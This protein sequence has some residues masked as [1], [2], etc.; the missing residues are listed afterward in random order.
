[1][2]PIGG[3]MSQVVQLPTH[4]GEP[5]FPIFSSMLGDVN[6]V[7]NPYSN[8][9]N[10]EPNALNGAGGAL[11]P[12]L[13]R[14]RAI[15]E[16]L[17]RYSSCVF[18]ERQFIWA[19]AEELGDEALDLNTVPRC[20]PAELAHPR[21]PL[22][23]PNKRAPIRWVR[24]V[25]LLDARPV[26]IPG[27]MAYLKLAMLS[28]GERF[29]LPISTGCA[30]HVT[31]EQALLAGVGEV[32]ER[33]SI[34]LVWLQQLEL[35][36]IELDEVPPSLGG[37]LERNARSANGVETLFFDATTE[38]G[39][40]TVYSL[41]VSPQNETLAA[42]VMCSTELDAATA[43]AKIIREAASSRIAMLQPRPVPESWDDFT[44]VM[45]GAA[46]MGR[47]AQ[48]PAFDFL[49]HSTGRRRLSDMP[50][51]A[52][53]DARRD[54]AGLLRRLRARGMEAFAVDLTT[55]EAVRAGMRVVK[56]I[57]PALQPLSFS[58]RARYLGHPRLY[59]APRLMGHPVRSEAKI[60]HWPQPFA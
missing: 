6:Q 52:T 9:R 50:V 59:E 27:V 37:Y 30:T 7:L 10:L 39:V 8:P 4:P 47:P 34:S 36:R 58:Y 12:D 51:L 23:A 57:I 17:E 33:D 56:V 46:F 32:I 45:H 18:D 1:M 54:L 48:L 41:G 28:A 24:G 20:S 49:R 2:Q 42:L 53:G 11:E 14:I 43:I 3:L 16:G 29:H 19:T 25:S 55:D 38:V 21:C 5:S 15:A 40:P 44:D 13:G 31:V 22:L 35:P 60:N 26:W